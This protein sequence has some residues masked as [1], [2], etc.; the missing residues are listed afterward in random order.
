[1]SQKP[2]SGI[3]VLDFT[4]LFAGPFCTMLLGDLG[5]DVVKVE[6]PEGDPIRKQGPPFHHG[7]SMS[8]LAV[9]RNKRST[10][11]NMKCP[12]GK[13]VA[14]RLAGCADVL[15]ENFRPDVMGRLGLGYAALRTGNPGLIYVSISGMG[16]DGPARDVGGFDLT[17]QAEGG[18]MS[19][20]GERNAKPVKLGT[21]AFDLICG[22]YA[23]NAITTALFQRERTGQ[24]QA[25]QTS[26][27]ESE[28]TFLVDAA[29]EYLTLGLVRGKWGSEHAAQAPYKAFETADG[30]LVIGAGMQNLF[31]AFANALGLAEQLLTDPRFRTVRDRSAN[32]D[33]LHAIL[34]AAVKRYPT[35]E[36]QK[37]LSDAKVP[38]APVNTTERVFSHPQALHRG[39]VQHVE[40]PRYG[41]LALVGP[42]VKYSGFDVSEGWMAPPDLGEQTPRVLQDWLQVSPEESVRLADAITG[43]DEPAGPPR[44][45]V[46]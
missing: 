30:W 39:M 44:G 17:I 5:A 2:L 28:I 40:H 13:A 25:I 8:Y 32:R 22:Q 38:C 20:T 45:G 33:A 12:A 27:F 3:R 6:S 35:A 1:M 19:I 16:A 18:Y 34:D 37:I 43:I 31:E 7:H 46:E 23:A 14:Q 4:R 15:V 21:S 24:G 10:V 41:P 42:A 26:L 9:N 36:L 11:V 29:M